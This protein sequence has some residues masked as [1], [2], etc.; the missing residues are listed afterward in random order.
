MA[1]LSKLEIINCYRGEQLSHDAL[2][3]HLRNAGAQLR[4]CCHNF[5]VFFQFFM[6][7]LELKSTFSNKIKTR[8]F[9]CVLII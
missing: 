1:Y 4:L 6:F 5:V 2:R 3:L 7:E 9:Y 8:S